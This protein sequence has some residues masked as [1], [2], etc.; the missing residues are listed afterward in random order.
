MDCCWVFLTVCLDGPNMAQLMWQ[1]QSYDLFV[2]HGQAC[3]NYQGPVA[4]GSSS[5]ERMSF[6]GADDTALLQ[7]Y[8][9]MTLLLGLTINGA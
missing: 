2:P 4:E 9:T 1:F 7:N 8:C 5:S 3:R 6:S